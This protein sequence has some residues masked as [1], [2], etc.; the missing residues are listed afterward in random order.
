MKNQIATWAELLEKPFH[1]YSPIS[2][3]TKRTVEYYP[4]IICKLSISARSEKRKGKT[5]GLGTHTLNDLGFGRRSEDEINHC[6]IDLLNLPYGTTLRCV[7]SGINHYRLPGVIFKRRVH[8]NTY[9]PYE[10]ITNISK[11]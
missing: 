3:E 1:E 6:K 5:T 2:A 8:V 11:R 10:F 4:L 9:K 7:P